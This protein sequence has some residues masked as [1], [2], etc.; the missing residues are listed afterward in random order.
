MRSLFE[1]KRLQVRELCLDD[2]DSLMPIFG[3][4]EIMR[5]SLGGPMDLARAKVYLEERIL[6]SY[7]EHGV[8]LWGLFLKESKELVGIAGLLYQKIER[9]ACFEVGY[10]LSRSFWGKGLATEAVLGIL[11]YAFD[12]L[13][14][15]RLISIIDPT[16]E[17]SARVA[18]RAG[19]LP[20]RRTSFHGHFVEI[21]EIRKLQ[22]IPYDPE[23]PKIYDQEKAFLEEAFLGKGVI[24]HHIGST[25]IQGCSAKPIIDILGVTSD[26]L[27]LDGIEPLGYGALGEFGMPGRRFFRKSGDVLVNLHIFED[28]DPEGGRHLR[29]R[30]YLRAHPEKKEAYSALK[31]RLVVKDSRD[32]HS[33]LFGKAAFIKE[34]DILA[35]K[36]GEP[37]A[38]RE[39]L[40]RKDFSKEEL[41]RAM[42]VNMH[43]QMTYFARYLPEVTLGVEPDVALLSSL[44]P[45]DT[46]NYIFQAQLEKKERVQEILQIFQEK[47]G[48]FSWWVSERD[49][50][51]CLG[52]WLLEAG[53][54]CKEED[55]G[56]HTFLD[57]VSETSSELCIEPARNLE[58]FAKVFRSLGAPRDIYERFFQKIPPILYQEESAIRY[59]VSYL[60]EKPVGTGM[61]VL[62]ANVA[63]IYYVMTDPEH[64]CKGYATAMMHYLMCQAKRRGY[65]VAV[66]QASSSGKRLYERLGFQAEYLVR[67]YAG[68]A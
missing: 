13:Q 45:D 59:F 24:F 30:D 67:E 23:W 8:G 19:M 11:E 68:I 5:Y 47:G 52:E 39:V 2:L 32:I 66:L 15:D 20:I 58:D 62:H 22:Q 61:L 56:M 9:E 54:V 35:T 16:N 12:T 21:Y 65:H 6:A 18:K 25:S 7:R 3:D 37:C 55:V 26:V 33:Y 17:R 64:R 57:E 41:L 48:P 40:R 38:T 4:A 1:T 10:R 53:L 14:I 28:T 31:Q 46:F 42:E 34:I 43:L 60:G 50:P 49:S 51:H 44:I 36:E 27:T 63:G 29:F